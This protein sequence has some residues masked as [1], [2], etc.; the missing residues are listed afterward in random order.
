[1]VKETQKTYL[2]LN[3]IKDM[4]SSELEKLNFEAIYKDMFKGNSIATLSNGDYIFIDDLIQTFFILVFYPTHPSTSHINALYNFLEHNITSS[5]R[6]NTDTLKTIFKR[7]SITLPLTE[8]IFDCLYFYYDTGAKF[9]IYFNVDSKLQE[10]F[11]KF[12]RSAALKRSGNNCTHHYKLP[13]TY[14][15]EKVVDFMKISEPISTSNIKI[16][17]KCKEENG[18]SYLPFEVICVPD[19]QELIDNIL[20]FR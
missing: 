4:Y 9:D 14:K 7:D 20:E 19:Q 6:I 2:I 8:Y 5:F 16:S 1:M 18:E 15:F 17:I 13:D 3:H 10:P 12:C 11:S